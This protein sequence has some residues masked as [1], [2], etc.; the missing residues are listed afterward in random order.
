MLDSPASPCNASSSLKQNSNIHLDLGATSS[1]LKD[2]VRLFGS[3]TLTG[4]ALRVLA[5]YAQVPQPAQRAGDYETLLAVSAALA[6]QG[7]K[8]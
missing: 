3:P 8:L 7:E 6:L 5:Y 4:R 1:E 2:L